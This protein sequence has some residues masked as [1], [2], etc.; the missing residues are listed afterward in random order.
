VGASGIGGECTVCA[1]PAGIGDFLDLLDIEQIEVNVFRGPRLVGNRDRVFGGQ[2]A[3][4]ALVAA[5]RT[6]DEGAVHSLHAYFLRPGDPAAPILYNVDRIRDGRSFTTRRVVAIQHGQAIF[7]LACSFHIEETGLDHQTEIPAVPGPDEIALFG[8][9]PADRPVGAPLK[10]LDENGIDIRFL[11][12][13][14][15][16]RTDE[17]ARDREQLWIRA[18]EPLPDD[19]TLHAA[20]ATFASDLTLVGTIL[21][22]HGISPWRTPYFGASLDHCMWFHRPFRADGWLFYDQASPTAYGGRGLSLGSLFEQNGRL[23]ATV[24]QEGLVR[25]GERI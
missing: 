24:A 15:W 12:G 7:N 11:G 10:Y 14:P 5:G 25:V 19:P 18:R 21:A 20:I 8:A 2:V 6:V 16:S 17:R 23:V 13:P 9:P 3:A 1:V 4:Q 22:R